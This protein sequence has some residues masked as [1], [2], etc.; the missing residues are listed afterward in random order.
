MWLSRI[1]EDYQR[2]MRV[3]FWFQIL[4]I[5]CLKKISHHSIKEKK[6]MALPHNLRIMISTN[7]HTPLN[8]TDSSVF[9][10]R[11]SFVGQKVLNLS[12]TQP[13]KYAGLIHNSDLDL[14]V[15]TTQDHSHLELFLLT[16]IRD[17]NPSKINVQL[18]L[19]HS[20]CKIDLT[21]VALVNANAKSHASATIYM[22]PGIQQ[23]SSTL[24]EETIILGNQVNVRNLP[25]LDIQANNIAAAHGAKIYRLDEQKLFYLQSKGLSDIAARQLLISSYPERLFDA[26]LEDAEIKEKLITDF[27]TFEMRN[28]HA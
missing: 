21:I 11:D 8:L 10:L 14:Q 15:N 12:N 9:E 22:E 16:P 28:T 6:T 2:V 23:S 26:T 1:D 13:L 25:I 4:M 3:S 17:N 20:H 27:L 19:L 24:L 5:Y 18:N 7:N